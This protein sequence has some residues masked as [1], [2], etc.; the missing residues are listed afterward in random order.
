MYK[1]ISK[2]AKNI[3]YFLKRRIDTKK[4]KEIFIILKKIYSFFP[5]Y[6]IIKYYLNKYNEKI[7]AILLM[8]H[9]EIILIKSINDL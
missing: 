5:N 6:K 4:N 9:N 3:F 2:Y 8:L 7:C 1:I